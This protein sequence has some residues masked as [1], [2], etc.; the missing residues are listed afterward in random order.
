MLICF[1]MKIA[2]FLYSVFLDKF[3]FTTT[4]IAL[5]ILLAY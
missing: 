3:K 1:T 2:S 5:M 4:K